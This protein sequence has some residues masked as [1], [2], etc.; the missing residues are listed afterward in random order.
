MAEGNVEL[1]RRMVEAFLRGD[2]EVALECI[3]PDVA[4]YSFE[5]RDLIDAGAGRVVSVFHE[6][7]TGR[8]SGLAVDTEFAGIYEVRDGQVV[9][10]TRYPSR[11]DAERAA[12]IG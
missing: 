3:S 2:M 10:W 1:V 8:G 12:G 5:Q 7:G 6:R 9:A 4:D 11:A